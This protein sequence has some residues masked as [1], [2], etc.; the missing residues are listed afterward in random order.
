MEQ[1]PHRGCEQTKSRQK[2]NQVTS[3]SNWPRVPLFDLVHKQCNGIIK[4]WLHCLTSESKGK[5]LVNNIL[6][7][8]SV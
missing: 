3:H 4:R 7:F 1:Q 5:F 8:G 6:I 2:Q